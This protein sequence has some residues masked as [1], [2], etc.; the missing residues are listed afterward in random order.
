MTTQDPKQGILAVVRA[1]GPIGW[2]GIEIHLRVPRSEFQDG[3]TLRT[4]LEELIADGLLV[5][6][7]VDGNECFTA[8]ASS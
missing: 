7:M 6:T 2:Y 4:Y 3:Y 5:R 8:A 1:R